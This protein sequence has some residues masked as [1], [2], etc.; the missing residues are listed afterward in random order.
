MCTKHTPALYIESNNDWIAISNTYR[1]HTK[2]NETIVYSH[3]P[4]SKS[5]PP[6]GID[7]EDTVT[8]TLIHIL[9]MYYCL[10]YAICQHNQCHKIEFQLNTSKTVISKRGSTFN[11]ELPKHM[12]IATVLQ[13]SSRNTTLIF[14]LSVYCGLQTRDSLRKHVTVSFR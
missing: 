14:S 11:T 2:K 9:G 5:A 4:S 12:R 1:V 7:R 13:V 3:L 10:K 6:W 8:C